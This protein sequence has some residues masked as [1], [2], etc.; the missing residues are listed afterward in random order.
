MIQFKE[1]AQTDERKDGQD[2]KTEE[3]KMDRP[4]FIGPFWLLPWVQYRT[5]LTIS[6]EHVRNHFLT[7]LSHLLIN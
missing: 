3:W 6:S 1:N 5:Q 2:G 7:I 4:Y